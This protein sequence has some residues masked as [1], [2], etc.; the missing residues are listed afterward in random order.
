MKSR[1]AARTSHRAPQRIFREK[2]NSDH[3]NSDPGFV[4]RHLH[5]C[6]H[7]RCG[8]TIVRVRGSSFSP[9]SNI[10][11]YIFTHVLI[12]KI[13]HFLSLALSSKTIDM[14]ILRV[15]HNQMSSI[16]TP[17]H[18]MRVGDTAGRI[19]SNLSGKTHAAVCKFSDSRRRMSIFEIFKYDTPDM[20]F[21]ILQIQ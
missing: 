3:G 13:S 2:K 15:S 14:I 20:I 18:Y 7:H 21:T 10:S 17:H 6:F 9:I 4:F 11:F 16:K 19:V 5:F 12:F 1:S 8:S